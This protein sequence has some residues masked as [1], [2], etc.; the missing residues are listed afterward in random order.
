M[1]FPGTFGRTR[2]LHSPRPCRQ[3]VC[4]RPTPP[5]HKKTAR[6]RSN[7][8]DESPPSGTFRAQGR[9]KVVTLRP[10]SNICEPKRRLRTIDG[11]P[12]HPVKGAKS[13]LRVTLLLACNGK[14]KGVEKKVWS[15]VCASASVNG[16]KIEKPL[17]L[18][19]QTIWTVRPTTTPDFTA[20]CP[21]PTIPP[22]ASLAFPALPPSPPGCEKKTLPFIFGKPFPERSREGGGAGRKGGRSRKRATAFRT[23]SNP[24]LR[25][26]PKKLTLP[27]PPQPPQR[28]KCPPLS[29]SPSP[30]S[31]PPPPSPPPTPRRDRSEA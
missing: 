7:L 4:L 17:P 14:K 26:P 28:K 22:P 6:S 9:A 19:N 20:T 1:D 11:H 5:P 3:S 31:S 29:S 27:P 21:Q 2:T 30:S 16:L 12:V 25:P 15:S 18:P 23:P 24:H 8:A 10:S 13:H